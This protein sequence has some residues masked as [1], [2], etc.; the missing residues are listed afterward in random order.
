MEKKGQIFLLIGV[1]LS[2]ASMIIS[3]LERS[4]DW[5]DFVS[6]MFTGMGAV[7]VIWGIIQIFRSKRKKK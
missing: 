2:L 4:G 5:I 7:F 3:R 1:L 6:G